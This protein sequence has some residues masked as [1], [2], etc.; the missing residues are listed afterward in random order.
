M[1]VGSIGGTQAGGPGDVVNASSKAGASDAVA[2]EKI[3]AA[4]KK[5]AAKTPAER[6]R[7]QVLKKHGLTEDSYRTLPAEQKKAIDAE[8]ASAV[9]R[10]MRADKGKGFRGAESAATVTPGTNGLPGF[11][12]A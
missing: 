5:E 11:L 9:Q 6:A 7:D 10:V 12:A 2:F 4:F 1:A 8:I 3:L